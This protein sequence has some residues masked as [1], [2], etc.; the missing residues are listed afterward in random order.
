MGLGSKS[1]KEL[2]INE[3][4]RNFIDYLYTSPTSHRIQMTDPDEIGIT[5]DTKWVQCVI[6]D[7]TTNDK[8]AY[9]EKKILVPRDTNIDVGCYFFWDNCYWLIIFKEHKSLE[10]YKKFIATRC[11]QIFK[12]KYEGTVYEIP[13]NIA[14]LTMYSDGLADLKYTSQQDS[15]RMFTFG[16]NPVTRSIVANTRVMLTRKTVFRVTHI[17]D[18]EYNGAYTGANGVIKTLVLQTTIRDDDDLENNIAWNE[19]SEA[20]TVI[21]TPLQIIGEKKIM[22]GSKKTYKAEGMKFSTSWR[23][24]YPNSKVKDFATIKINSKN[25]LTAQ[26]TTNVNYVGE[27]FNIILFDVNSKEVYDTLEVEIKGFI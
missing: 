17:N 20:P 19:N 23:I 6:N 24:E 16:S 3:L 7:L 13:V 22:V 2:T 25:E 14:N 10:T 21:E 11:N 5:E 12:Y 1:H 9:D 26:V 4:E 27:S 18:F 8:K 15:K